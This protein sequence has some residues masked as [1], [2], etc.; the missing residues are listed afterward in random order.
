MNYEQHRHLE[1]TV[2]EIE[3]KAGEQMKKE[4]EEYKKER[5]IF[6]LPF[7]IGH[8]IFERTRKKDY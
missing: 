3:K 1:L 2:T 7:N 4:Y 8:I 5:K 6:P